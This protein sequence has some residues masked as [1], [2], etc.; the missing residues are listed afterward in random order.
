MP[1]YHGLV[2]VQMPGSLVPGQWKK[3]T[4][5]DHSEI[6]TKH[7]IFVVGL[8]A[9][10]SRQKESTTHPPTPGMSL[11]VPQNPMGSNFTSPE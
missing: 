2:P 3:N 5:L 11:K 4:F 1:W 10:C 9:K 6:Q 7:R 8:A